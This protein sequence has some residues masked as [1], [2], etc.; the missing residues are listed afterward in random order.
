MFL[1]IGEKGIYLDLG[2]ASPA[3][4]YHSKAAQALEAV[5]REVYMTV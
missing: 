4:E 1:S 5:I 2:L 3:S